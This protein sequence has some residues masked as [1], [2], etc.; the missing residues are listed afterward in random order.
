M[1]S[2]LTA[3]L[4]ANINFRVKM[5]RCSYPDGTQLSEDHRN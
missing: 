4:D 3:L 2:C 1:G 5:G